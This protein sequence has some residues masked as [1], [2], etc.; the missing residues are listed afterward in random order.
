MKKIAHSEWNG[1]HTVACLYLEDGAYHVRAYRLGT[2]ELKDY[3][4]DTV[5]AKFAIAWYAHVVAHITERIEAG[6]L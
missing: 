1:S 4:F 5:N 2:E 6:T 3:S